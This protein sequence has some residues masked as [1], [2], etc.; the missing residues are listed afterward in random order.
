MQPLHVIGLN[1]AGQ[2]KHTY[3]NTNGSWQSYLGTITLP[4]VLNNI[5]D[6]D[7]GLDEDGNLHVIVQRADNKTFYAQRTNSGPWIPFIPLDNLLGLAPNEMLT[8]ISCSCVEK[9]VHLWGSRSKGGAEGLI[10]HSIRAANGTWTRQ[11]SPDAYQLAAISASAFVATGVRYSGQNGY[12]NNKIHYF[13]LNNQT[14][15]DITVLQGNPLQ[16]VQNSN[17]IVKQSTTLFNLLGLQVAFI[18]EDKRLY[19]TIFPTQSVPGL[20]RPKGQNFFFQDVACTYKNNKLH[21]VAVTDNYQLLHTTRH[22]NGTW[23][24]FVNIE[25][26]TSEGGNFV[27]VCLS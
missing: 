14:T 7:C 11:T 10:F 9:T 13:Y 12:V 23:D 15:F 3:R 27:K 22:N 26:A 24:G 4:N 18:T 17:F 1:T 5:K 19:H 6:I 2:L 20:V 16:P 8:S 25:Q 21:L